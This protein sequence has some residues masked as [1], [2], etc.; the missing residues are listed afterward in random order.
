MLDADNPTTPVPPTQ[1]G[2]GFGIDESMV[3]LAQAQAARTAGRV[4]NLDF[5]VAKAAALPFR[6]GTFDLAFCERGPM[7]YND[8][9]LREALRVLKPGGLLFIEMVG[10]LNSW[11]TRV[12]FEPGFQKP[13]AFT[14]VLEG[15]GQRLV[16]HGVQVHTL[17]SRIQLIEFASLEDWLRYQLHTWSPPGREAFTEDR[18]DA[19]QRFA[20][21]ASG[22]DGWICITHHALWVAGTKGR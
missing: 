13:A 19:I 20:D 2:R 10:D 1:V 16:R 5:Q 15:E 11:E 17:A 12:A 18:L 21:I 14:T 9:T 6:D 3:M 7:G 22:R 8:V 4:D